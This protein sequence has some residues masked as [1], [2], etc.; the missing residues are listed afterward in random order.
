MDKLE[1]RLKTE[2]PHQTV[3]HINKP[4]QINN[5]QDADIATLKS[6]FHKL[7]TKNHTV[8]NVVEI[9]LKDGSKLI[10]QKSTPI[11]IQLQPAVEKE[12]EQLKKQENIK[13][14]KVIDENCF[15][16]PAVITIKNNKST[17]IALDSQKLNELTIERKA[18]LSIME[19]LISRISREIADGPADEIWDSKFDL[20]YAS[21]R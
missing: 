6:K 9:R 1:I 13:K 5:R 8:N 15:L 20:D 3:N 14:A 19:E 10:Q 4:D 12:I 17:K 11:P 18:Q 16:S 2:T 21:G 7:F